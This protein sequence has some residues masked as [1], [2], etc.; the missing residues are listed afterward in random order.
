MKSEYPF[1]TTYLSTCG[2]NSVHVWWNHEYQMPEPYQTGSGPYPTEAMAV[3]D[4]KDWSDNSGIPFI[5][6]NAF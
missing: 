4:A 1:I 6:E 3:E 2:Y 5:P